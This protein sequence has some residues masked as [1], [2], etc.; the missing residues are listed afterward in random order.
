MSTKRSGMVSIIGRPNVGKSTLINAFVGEKVAIVAPKPQTTR[1]RICG[2]VNDGGTQIV[3]IDTPGFHKPR[4]ALGEY[5]TE[6]VKSS[7]N[8]VDCVLLVVE[9]DPNVGT[10]EKLLLE[11]VKH[12]PC[13]LVINKAD[14]IKDKKELL[15]VIAAYQN[16]RE[17]AAIVPV[18]AQKH[19]GL[20]IL[21]EI[22]MP[23]I[24]EGEP[25][26]PPDMTSD[27]SD[28]VLV[29]EIIREK[30]LRL[31]DKEVPHGVAVMLER[32]HQREDGLVEI[33]ATVLC[34]KNSHKGIIIGKNGEQLGKIG[35][36]ARIELERMYGEKVLLKLWV[37]IKENWRDNAGVLRGLGYN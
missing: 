13:V 29:S 1:T 8:D 20:D 3:F 2:V 5:M 11:R 30:V 22:I 37:K 36:S 32:L 23:F 24:P 7:V 25:L 27:Q 19:D 21:M 35:K 16:E 12:L 10:Q 4:T 6:A 17:F 33:F 28:E 18:S 34:E 9:P 31:L 26:F 14:T 15:E